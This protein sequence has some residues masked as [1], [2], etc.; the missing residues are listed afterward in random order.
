M[1]NPFP[2]P[3]PPRSI[4]FRVSARNELTDL[5]TCY[6]IAL[7]HNGHWGNSL[8][9]VYSSA[10]LLTPNPQPPTLY[11]DVA[12]ITIEFSQLSAERRTRV[13]ERMRSHS[14]SR[15]EILCSA[16]LG[17]ASEYAYTVALILILLLTSEAV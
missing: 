15:C 1:P 5:F 6:V 13:S 9:T 7:H 14:Q 3:H 16:K 17:F 10:S 2:P 8:A 12:R 11:P 4:L